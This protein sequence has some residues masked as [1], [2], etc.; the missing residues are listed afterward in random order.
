MNALVLPQDLGEFLGRLRIT[1]EQW[2]KLVVSDEKFPLQIGD[3]N[4]GPQTLGLTMATRKKL[5]IVE[6]GEVH[7]T[8]G[9]TS[10][11]YFGEDPTRAAL[12]GSNPYNSSKR[13]IA[14][15]KEHLRNSTFPLG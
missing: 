9:S 13:S 3:A 4:N 1:S 11:N 15:H 2:T 6:Y 14:L 7:Q 8:Y 12:Q 5:L 10:S